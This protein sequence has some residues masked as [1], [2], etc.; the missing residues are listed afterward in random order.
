MR[1]TTTKRPLLPDK[2]LNGTASTLRYVCPPIPLQLTPLHISE[3][4]SSFMCCPF[5]TIE[6]RVSLA[7]RLAVELNV[8][9]FLNPMALVPDLDFLASVDRLPGCHCQGYHCFSHE[10]AGSSPSFQV[11][12]GRR[13]PGCPLHSWFVYF[14]LC[15]FS[16]I[17][18]EC[19]WGVSCSHY[20]PCVHATALVCV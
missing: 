1:A 4:A 13:A 20:G 17:Q 10:Y 9:A 15:T 2:R 14:T 11:T 5:P 7:H 12:H 6:Q 18:E 8:R 3:D 16:C 19:R